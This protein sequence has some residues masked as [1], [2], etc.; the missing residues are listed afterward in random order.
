M[1]PDQVEEA[2][3]RAKISKT[4]PGLMSGPAWRAGPS[5]TVSDALGKGRE[6]PPGSDIIGMGAQK[7]NPPL[8]QQQ[9]PMQVVS[10]QAGPE[11]EHLQPWKCLHRLSQ[12]Y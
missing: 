8:V 5:S 4:P 12:V 1:N 11:S 7:P 10:L 3:A 9:G 2:S 6:A